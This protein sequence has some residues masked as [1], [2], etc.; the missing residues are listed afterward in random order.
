L[1]ISYLSNIIEEK[2][3]MKELVRLIFLLLVIFLSGCEEDEGVCISSTGKTITQ[4]RSGLSYHYVEVYDNIN[5]FLTQDSLF[6]GIKVEAG[7]NLID[8]I[9]TEIDSGRLVIR[10]TNSCNWL[11]SFNVPVNVY[12]NFTKLDTLNFRAAGNVTCTNEWTNDSMFVNILEGGGKTNLKLNVFK[13]FLYI[14]DGTVSLNVTGY[15]QVTYISSHGYG[16][17]HAENLLSKFTYTFSSSPNDV[18]LN[19]SVGLAVRITNIG[20]VYYSGDPIDIST[21]ITGGGKLIKF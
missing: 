12:L 4:D 17:V 8:G 6:T 18:Y 1:A 21:D 7:E 3:K 15:S 13:S 9:T 19:A 16:P 2:K 14:M 10:N 20:N 11:R 5:L